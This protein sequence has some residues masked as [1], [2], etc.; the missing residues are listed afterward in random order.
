MADNK[1]EKVEDT[2][3]VII[4]FDP[5]DPKRNETKESLPASEAYS[6][7]QTGRARPADGE[8]AGKKAEKPATLS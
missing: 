5:D 3:D 2:I 4:A 8:K 1:V 6:L 7:I